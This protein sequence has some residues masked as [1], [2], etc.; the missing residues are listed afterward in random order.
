MISQYLTEAQKLQKSGDL[1]G[2]ERLF[3]QAIDADPDC[4]EAHHHMGVL[5]WQQKQPDA[6]VN[7]FQ[8]AVEFD[9]TNPDYLHRLGAVLGILSRYQESVDCFRRAATIS[10]QAADIHFN[11]GNALRK[12]KRSEE[13]IESYR[14]AV[15]C[16]P[17]YAE[18]HFNLG[19]EYRDSGHTDQ[20]V[21]SYERALESRPDYQKA[22]NNLARVLLELGGQSQQEEAYEQAVA[23]YRRAT[24]LAPESAA[25]WC[26]LGSGL[27]FQKCHQEAIEANRRALELNSELPDAHVNLGVCLR[28]L[29][30]HD[31][32]EEHLRVAMRLKPDFFDAI[33]NYGALLTS[34]QK[35]EEALGYCQK[36]REL[37][38]ESVE[39]LTNEASVL[40]C[41]NR[42]PEAL[43]RFHKALAKK[44]E[45]ASMHFNLGL[46]HYREP[47][48]ENSMKCYERALSI[49]PDYPEARA[50]RAMQL[51]ALGE[52]EEGWREY[53]WRWQAN[54]FANDDFPFPRWDGSSLADKTILVRIEQG[55]GDTFQFIRYT[56]L[57]KQQGAT[58]FFECVKA[59]V[60]VISTCRG[61][62]QVIERGDP[63]PEFDV[64][65]P[66]M[67]IPTLVGTTVDTVPTTIPYLHPEAKLVE[68]WRSFLSEYDGLKV[69]VSWH[70]NKEKEYGRTRSFHVSELEPLAQLAG[71]KLFSLQQ[72]DGIEELQDIEGRFEVVEF[73]DDFDKSSGSFMDTAAVIA[74]LDLVISC[75]SAVTHL[76]GAVGCETWLALPHPAEWRWMYDRE[77]TLWYP[78]HRLFRQPA[79]GDWKSVFARME[80]ELS[81]RLRAAP[82]PAEAEP[83]RSASSSLSSN[84][85]E[86]KKKSESTTAS[87]ER[88]VNT[89]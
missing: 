5:R 11:L 12:L 68:R 38:P 19:N 67:S 84:A 40:A 13:A 2:A 36:A 76:A 27:T 70:G 30:K 58:V 81:A 4:A 57:L 25:A 75:D 85:A 60:P 53:E 20:A 79:Y 42:R 88:A 44:P 55:F 65:I 39:A 66:L 10:P 35:Y 51:L 45:D 61:V 86:A 47:D 80:D 43:E 83:A 73:G 18:A 63:L 77:D 32:A 15:R 54:E 71:V 72:R 21:A 22:K 7:C 28:E 24:E 59:L 8:R 41:L 26:H 3:Q 46:V 82:E 49:R 31:K 23:Q 74:N 69:G 56:E 64:Y 33:L 50:A 14:E 87:P 37:N 62:D 1:G 48:L 9:S 17:G 29:G 6:A 34:Q 16:R 89:A 52:F 78:D